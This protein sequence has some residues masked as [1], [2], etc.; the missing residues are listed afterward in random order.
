MDALLDPNRAPV[1]YRAEAE[2]KDGLRVTIR[3]LR[4]ADH[5]RLAKAAQTVDQQSIYL[6]FFAHRE[7]VD[8]DIERVIGFGASGRV[9]L[10]ATVRAADDEVIVG[11]GEYVATKPHCADIAFI[12]EEQYRKRGICGCLLH[13]LAAIAEE[14]GITTF[15]ADVLCENAPMQAVLDQAPWPAKTRF[16][17]NVRHYTI[18]LGN[19]LS[20]PA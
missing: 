4:P 5:A 16:E 7:L 10:A 18:E 1:E 13:H 17:G 15:D 11:V 3:T 20:R 6:R 2:L 12:V 9:A 14:R 8:N 19:P